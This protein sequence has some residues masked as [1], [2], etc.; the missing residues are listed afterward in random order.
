MSELFIKNNQLIPENEWKTI[1]QN[2]KSESSTKPVKQALFDAIKKRS[3]NKIG[4]LF[5]GGVDSTVLAL[6]LKELEIDFTCFAIGIRR[7]KDVKVPIEIAEK[8]NLDLKTKYFTLEKI[9]N[10]IEN[11]IKIFQTDDFVT[12]SVGSV[13]YDAAKLAKQ[14]GHTKVLTG[15]GSEEIFG[16]YYRHK[17]SS[18][19][20]QE[21]WNGMINTLWKRD[22]QRDTTIAKNLHM[23]FST[24]FLDKEL[25]M[26]AMQIQGEQKVKD[27]LA[28]LPL[29]KIA[30][31][32]GLENQYAMRKKIA[33]QY[34]SGFDK[35]IE[36]IAKSKGFKYKSDYLKQVLT[37]M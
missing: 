25:I 37:K 32:I 9:E 20:N 35:A 8:Y 5:S 23:Q 7:S 15:L 28:K 34:G 26:A 30:L 21:C 14:H 16:G 19:V 1:I 18:N 33:A 31:E 12:I 17:T 11:L 36:K 29:R 6:I 2:L 24:P 3:G 13:I 4:L 10:T 27:G 22:L